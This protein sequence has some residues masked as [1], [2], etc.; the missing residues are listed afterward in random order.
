[1]LRD[2]RVISYREFCELLRDPN[3]L[4]WLRRL[5]EYYIVTGSGEYLDRVVEALNAMED[6]LSFLDEKVGGGSSLRSIL[7]TEGWVKQG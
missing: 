7:E 3:E 2:N 6:L 4:V 5:I 1:M